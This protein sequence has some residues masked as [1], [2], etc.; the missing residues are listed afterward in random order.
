MKYLLQKNFLS[1][2]E[3]YHRAQTRSR[4]TI[5]EKRLIDLI[6]E[7]NSGTTRADVVSIFTILNEVVVRELLRGYSFALP[8]FKTSFS[9]KGNFLGAL[10]TYDKERHEAKIRISKGVL[11]RKAEKNLRPEL[12]TL[13]YVNL[14]I[15]EVKDSFSGIVNDTLTPGGVVEIKGRQLSIAGDDPSIGVWFVGEDATETSALKIIEN[16]PAK[17]MAVIPDLPVGTYQVKVATQYAGG[18]TFLKVPRVFVYQKKL[19]VSD[20]TDSPLTDP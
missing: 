18:K 6:M 11:L 17:I 1:N 4:G 13:E 10:D 12:T 14:R 8:I 2:R 16:K 20:L 5:D 3:E 15:K 19:T 7:Y 9:I